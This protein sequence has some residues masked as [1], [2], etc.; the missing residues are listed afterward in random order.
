M[1][2][3]E[4]YFH[5]DQVRLSIER[6]HK[7]YEYEKGVVIGKLEERKEKESGR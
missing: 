5:T 4:Q 7:P 1:G 2:I 6:E 3:E